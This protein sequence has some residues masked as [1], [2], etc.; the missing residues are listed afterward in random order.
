MSDCSTEA[1]KPKKSIAIEA[2]NM[3]YE[4]TCRNIAKPP[5][6]GFWPSPHF[7]CDKCGYENVTMDYLHYCGGCGAKVIGGSDD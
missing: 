1:F 7:K 2:R 4:H 6:E 5:K 3:R